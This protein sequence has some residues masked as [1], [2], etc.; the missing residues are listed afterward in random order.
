[1]TTTSAT[2]KVT[3]DFNGVTYTDQVTIAKVAEG[4]DSVLALLSNEATVVTTGFD[5]ATSGSSFTN[6]GGTMY[7]FDGIT[8]KTGNAA[9]TYSVVN[10]QNV[11]MS[12]AAT[13][14]YSVTD[15]AADMGSAT[16]RAVYKGVTIDKVYSIAKAKAGA[17]SQL[18]T[19]N[20]SSQVFQ[21]AK[22]GTAS[23]TSITL[24]A[25]GNN[26]SGAPT[27][28]VTSGTATLTGTG[29]SR[30]IAYS[31][32]TTDTATVQ[33]TWDGKT[34]YITL[35]K[36][37][38]GTDS[39]IGYLT[40]EAA[41]VAAATDGTPTESLTTLGGT[42]KVYKGITDVT[43]IAVTYSVASS[44]NITA[45]ITT[46]G[47]YNITAITA[48]SGRVTFRAVYGGVTIDKIYSLVKSKAGSVGVDGKRGTV[49]LSRAITGTAWSDT[50]ANLALSGA[51]YGVALNR[52][53]VTLYN[54][55]SSTFSQ[56]RFYNG[57][58]SAWL[59]LDSYLNGNMLI[60]GTVNANAVAAG[61][62][63]TKHLQ[64]ANG[65]NILNNSA[66]AKSTV[67]WYGHGNSTGKAYSDVAYD[68]YWCPTG[69]AAAAV[70]IVGTPLVNSVFDFMNKNK[71]A[72]RYPCK[73]N[74]RMEYSAYTSL[75]RCSG[76]LYVFYY[77]AAGNYIT[78][79][80]VGITYTPLS[81]NTSTGVGSFQRMVGM[82]TTPSNA[83]TF[84]AGVRGVCTGE[85]NPYI[86]ISMMYAGEA[87]PNQTAYSA[88]S[89]GG[90]TV[91]TPLMVE[92]PNL[93]S[94]SADLGAITGGSLNINGRFVVDG[95]GNVLI[96]GTG[97]QRM[98]MDSN[99]VRAY[100]SNGTMR[101]RL[102]IW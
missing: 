64:I 27:F 59:T 94:L 1:L 3:V 75:H 43:G 86:F 91:I 57:P 34:D 95:A 21:I 15:M 49:N 70:F 40:N 93:S 82:D 31:G 45:N 53:I 102:G 8:N 38:E 4:V 60:D 55:T 17:N 79:R 78:E 33:I 22:D 56:T 30:I 24:T 80:S 12:I 66:P 87:N 67:G 28:S 76:Y 37:R 58:S 2:I 35:V 29:S 23:P 92:T 90:M 11:T 52:D 63:Q 26:L 81:Q 39:I 47:V 25:V 10:P 62:I 9:V 5:G 68:T 61:A 72:R 96:K 16:L 32:M 20:A 83:A 65:K 14:V 44:S 7:V 85:A 42:F 97:N 50:E 46:A 74:Q 13:G 98:E 84:F 18:A 77:D 88:W 54:T 99:S 19:L 51:G 89:E 73:G 6:A 36:V 41:L 48:D 69:A 71:D 100:D 101:V